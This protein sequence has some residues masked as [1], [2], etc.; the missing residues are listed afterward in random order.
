LKLFKS[1]FRGL[2]IAFFIAA[3]MLSLP[4]QLSASEDG[5]P[6]HYQDK[7]ALLSVGTSNAQVRS[8]IPSLSVGVTEIIKPCYSNCADSK[9]SLGKLL[10]GTVDSYKDRPGWQYR[11]PV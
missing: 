7:A 9:S 11:S 10:I 3:M 1:Y 4:V 5:I 2:F 8:L 6:L